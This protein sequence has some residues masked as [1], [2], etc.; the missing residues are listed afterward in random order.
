MHS[1]RLGVEALEPR[2][3]NEAEGA[4][5]NSVRPRIRAFSEGGPTLLP[6]A[7]R[8]PNRLIPMPIY[9][10]THRPAPRG[11]WAAGDARPDQHP[12]QHAHASKFAGATD[13]AATVIV[14]AS[15]SGR[16]VV[17]SC[18]VG[19]RCNRERV[20]PVDRCAVDAPGDDPFR[21]NADERFRVGDR[22]RPTTNLDT[23]RH[24]RVGA[25]EVVNDDRSAAVAVDIAELLGLSNSRPLTSIASNVHVF[26]VTTHSY[27]VKSNVW[28]LGCE[29]RRSRPRHR[30]VALRLER[31]ITR[32]NRRRG[33]GS[34]RKV[35]SS[36]AFLFRSPPS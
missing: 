20:A 4:N 11:V 16:G 26:T 23:A 7:R 18:V 10:V 32:H 19:S 1:V 28:G 29:P 3:D 5:Q 27:C 8:P 21:I 24:P 12:G 33:P 14:G 34:R 22:L 36:R 13:S 9:E 15:A 6:H 35:V 2:R 30:P 25:G 17:R 31:V